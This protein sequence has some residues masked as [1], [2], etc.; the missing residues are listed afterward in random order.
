MSDKE[1]E[2]SRKKTGAGPSRN[3]VLHVFLM[4]VVLS[5]VLSFLS[6]TALTGAGYVVAI[7]VL[8]AFILHRADRRRLRGSRAGAGG[9]YLFGHRV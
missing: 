5:A 1:K 2:K 6:T 8:V 7:L 4:S 3:W 9:V